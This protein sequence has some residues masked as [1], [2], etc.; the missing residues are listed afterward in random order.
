MVIPTDVGL[1]SS[2]NM[3]FL[4]EVKKRKGRNGR[5]RQ[6]PRLVFFNIFKWTLSLE[7]N[8]VEE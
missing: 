6:L 5:V 2:P 3:P 8:C 7:K 1:V 4:G